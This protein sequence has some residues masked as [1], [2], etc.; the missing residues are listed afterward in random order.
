MVLIEG[1][2]VSASTIGPHLLTDRMDLFPP[3]TVV[4]DARSREAYPYVL[5]R[6][7]K[8]P[9]LAIFQ[10]V[11]ILGNSRDKRVTKSR[12]GQTPALGLTSSNPQSYCGSGHLVVGSCP[13]ASATA[14]QAFNRPLLT[15]LPFKEVT[16]LTLRR[17]MSFTCCG[18]KLGFAAHIRAIVPVTCGVAI[19]VPL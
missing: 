11:S 9:A 16:S 5:I 18:D 4:L 14:L 10:K 8:A 17:R 1:A 19:E 2:S 12:G 15:V 3:V 13:A 7:T 6:A